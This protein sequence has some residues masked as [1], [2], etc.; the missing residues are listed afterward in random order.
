MTQNDRNPS[1]EGEYIPATVRKNRPMTEVTEP[2]E[3]AQL[4][5]VEN[6]TAYFTTQP[7]DEQWG[8]DW[9]DAPY[10]HNAGTPYEPYG[11]RRG[12]WEVYVVKFDTY[13]RTP[14]EGHHNS[15]YSVEDINREK[16]IPWLRSETWDE[17]NIKVWAG[18]T[19]DEFRAAV[20]E[21]G[22]RVYLP[23]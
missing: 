20:E 6:Q 10:E 8:D 21:S 22:G 23:K 14:R 7:L 13:F 4:C 1:A 17:R 5:Y 16:A 15:P 2:P 18:A 9:D 12:D 11:G 19:F 3:A